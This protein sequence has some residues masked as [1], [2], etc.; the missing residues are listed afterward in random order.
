MKA[1][2]LWL[3]RNS[4]RALRH[5]RMR[6]RPWWR[7]LTKPVFDRQLWIPCRDSVASGSAIGA[8]FA[9]MPMPAQSLAAALLT[10]RCRGN[11][12]FAVGVCFLSNPLTNVPIWTAQ[13]WLGNFIQRHVPV[14]MPSVLSHME[15]TLPGL[16]AVNAGGFIVG[17]VASGCILAAVAFALAHC[18]ATLLPLHLPRKKQPPSLRRVKSTTG[19]H[20]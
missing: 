17:S 10:M 13:L 12:P 1:R 5:R 18:F 14:P 20:G 8:F 9:V 3:V 15:T 11:V 4:F 6:H 19:P 16:G 2:Y 7:K